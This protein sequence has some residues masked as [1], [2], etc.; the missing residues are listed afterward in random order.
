MTGRFLLAKR[1]LGDAS[2]VANVGFDSTSTGL[3]TQY[4]NEHLYRSAATTLACTT[5][6]S[7]HPIRS[8]SSVHKLWDSLWLLLHAQKRMI[9]YMQK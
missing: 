7:C 5:I 3:S 6:P 1:F 4:R 8:L 9:G 2:A